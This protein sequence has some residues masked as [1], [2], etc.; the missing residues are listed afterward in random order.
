VSDESVK[1]WTS[2]FDRYFLSVETTDASRDDMLFYV[3]K[4]KSEKY[5]FVKVQ[6]KF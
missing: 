1:F 6:I 2:L 5:G 3:R 4:P